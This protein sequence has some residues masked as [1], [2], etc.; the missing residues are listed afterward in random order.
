MAGDGQAEARRLPHPDV[1]RDNGIED[2][3]GEVLAHLPLDVLREPGATVVHGQ[4]HPGDGRG[5]G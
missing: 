5:A 3:L 4:G 2:E 1:A